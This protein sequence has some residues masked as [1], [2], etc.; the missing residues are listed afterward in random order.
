M[1]RRILTLVTFG[2]IMAATS[3]AC[4]RDGIQYSTG[5]GGNSSTKQYVADLSGANEVPPVAT[6][7]SGQAMF[8]LSADGSSM[9]Y[10]L[11]VS[12]INNPTAAHIHLAAAGVSGPVVV[13]LFGAPKVGAFSGILAEGTITPALFGGALAGMTMNDLIT[14]IEAGNTYVNIHTTQNPGGELRGQIRLAP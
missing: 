13:P 9:T 1:K 4:N 6:A 7:A 5:T 12:N 10:T 2:V 11:T 8:T 14:R 3:V